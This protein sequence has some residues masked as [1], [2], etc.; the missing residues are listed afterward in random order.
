MTERL[1]ALATAD[2]GYTVRVRP[3][4]VEV[5]TTRS[6]RARPIPRLLP[7]FSRITRVREDKAPGQ[8]TTLESCAAS[9][10]PVP[11]KPRRAL[12]TG[13]PAHVERVIDQGLHPLDENAPYA[14]GS[15]MLEGP[16]RHSS[17]EWM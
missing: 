9:T 13:L 15:S 10:T 16:L 12:A 8:A 3:S 17:R 14:A 1:R 2:D 6:Q 11:T 7:A 5:R 4:R